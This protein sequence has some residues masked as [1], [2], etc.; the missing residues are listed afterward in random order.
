M[1]TPTSDGLPD[2]WEQSAALDNG[3][4]RRRVD[5]DLPSIEGLHS[6]PQR[7]VFVEIDWMVRERRAGA[8][9]HT[10][11]PMAARRSSTPGP[12]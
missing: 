9:D 2:N 10:H 11:A 1:A 12:S 4:R 5:V 7:I 3:R 8:N 6:A